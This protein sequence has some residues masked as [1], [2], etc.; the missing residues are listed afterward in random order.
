M[1]MQKSKHWTR[2][3]VGCLLAVVLIFGV[4]AIGLGS[5]YVSYY[6][7]GVNPLPDKLTAAKV[8]SIHVEVKDPTI[9][10]GYALKEKFLT[11][12]E[13]GQLMALYNALDVE[14]LGL[15][16][17]YDTGNRMAGNYPATFHITMTGGEDYQVS[18]YAANGRTEKGDVS[19]GKVH[20]SQKSTNKQWAFDCPYET[21]DA[22]KEYLTDQLDASM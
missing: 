8:D 15:N 6:G 22:L 19:F 18:V 7:I 20:V 5:H 14:L 10:Y 16:P 11:D 12:E 17:L 1:T 13:Q 3:L 21:A 4:L 2:G 9:A